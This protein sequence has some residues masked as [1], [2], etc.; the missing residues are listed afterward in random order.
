METLA[1]LWS[2]APLIATIVVVVAIV[3]VIALVVRSRRSET[4]RSAPELQPPSTE[5]DPDLI[6]SSHIGFAP[7]VGSVSLPSRE[8]GKNGA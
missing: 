1:P 4:A 2:Y 6:D 8:R 3:F 7:L 5:I